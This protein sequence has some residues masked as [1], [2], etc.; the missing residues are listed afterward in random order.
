MKFGGGELQ[1]GVRNLVF[2]RGSERV[3]GVNYGG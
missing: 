2:S 3:K 1:E